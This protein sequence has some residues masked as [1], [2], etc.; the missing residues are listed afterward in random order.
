MP[1]SEIDVAVERKPG[2]QVSLRVTATAGEVDAAIDAS[3]RRLAGRVRIPGFRPGKAPAAM[4]ERAVG[5]EAVRH[6][7]VDHLVPELYERAL[8]QGGVEPVSE[9]EVEVD[10]LERDTPLTFT[11][12]VTVKP[13]VDL[14][15]YR[16]LRVPFERT[17]VTDETVDEAI[18]EIRRRRA[19]LREVERPAQAGDVLRCVLVMRRG[20]EVVGGEGGEERDLELDREAVLPGIVDGIIGLSAGE[21]RSFELTLPQDYPREELRGVTVTVDA[22]VNAVRERELPPLDDALAAQEKH[23]TVAEMREHLRE[24]LVQR[25]ERTDQERHEQAAL[26]ALREHVRVDVPQVMVEREIDR[27]LADLEYRLAAL[28]I[29]LERYVELSG[30]TVEQIR[31]D[32]RAASVQRVVLDL[33]LDALAA[34]E[35]IEVDEDQVRREAQRI[36]EGQRLNAAQRR[37]LEDVARRDLV[38]RAAALRVVEIAGGDGFVQT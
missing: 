17:E 5:W 22:T 6:E 28:G 34:E 38:R 9:P 36:A 11:A 30:Q 21:H 4:V 20:D 18:E 12:T 1:A 3:L 15:D 29:G 13:E 27:Q 19:T 14:R 32:R 26:T 31:G 7:T 23:E 25:A 10:A 33:A 37:R 16:S 24:Q 2:S 35:G 8:Q